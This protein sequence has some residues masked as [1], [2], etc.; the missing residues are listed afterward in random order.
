[1]IE[2]ILKIEFIKILSFDILMKQEGTTQSDSS[3]CKVL[4]L[5]LLAFW[6]I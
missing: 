5:K 4:I 6:I 1:M 2:E 3:I